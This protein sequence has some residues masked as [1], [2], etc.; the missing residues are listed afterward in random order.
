MRDIFLI[1]AM[2]FVIWGCL[3]NAT[4]YEPQEVKITVQAAEPTKVTV[5]DASAYENQ[6]I[7]QVPYERGS[8]SN[9]SFVIGDGAYIKLYSALSS[10]DMTNI[11]NDFCV[12]ASYDIKAVHLFINSP[13]GNAFTGLAIADELVRATK[14][15]FEITAYASG[16]VA[17]A[18]VPILAVCPQRLAAPGTIFMVHETSLWKWPGY[19]TAKDIRAQGKMIELLRDRYMMTLAK[20]TSLPREKWE[21]L[22]GQT[23]WFSAEQALEWGLVDEIN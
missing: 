14:K 21:H 2:G 5:G 16:I 1:V 20:Y 12:L 9:L 15:G 23:T 6:R 18:A 22:E 11:W 10:S 13:G 3:I 19:E 17:S 4:K 8:L 7:Q